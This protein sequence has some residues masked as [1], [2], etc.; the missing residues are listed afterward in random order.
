MTI[1][2]VLRDRLL[3]GSAAMLAL[4]V[5][6]LVAGSLNGTPAVGETAPTAL[7]KPPAD[8]VMGFVIERAVPPVL[9]GPDACPQGTVLRL[10]EE[11]LS[12][13]D[14][15]ERERLLKKENEPELDKRWRATAVGANDTNICSQPDMFER[16]QQRTVQ[17]KFAWGLDLDDGDAGDGCAHEEFASPDGRTGIDNQEYRAMG[18]TLEWRGKDGV[19]GDIASGLNQFHASGQWTQVLL[20]RGVDSLENDPDVEVIYANTSDRPT[21]GSNGKFLAHASF[22]VNDT[23]PRRRNML[24]GRI[25]NGVLVTEPEDIRLVQTWGQG[26]ARDIRGNRTQFDYR[27]A[28]LRLAFQ[29][30]GSLRG[31]M[32]GYRPVFDVI[33][34]PA[35]GGIGAAVAAG[36]DCAAVLSTL[37]RNA[38]GIRDPKTGKCTGVSSALDLAAVPAFVTDTPE[39]EA[40][41]RLPSGK[42]HS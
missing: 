11:Y 17:S 14:P 15:A 35:I 2:P 32:G 24:K 20:L 18:C 19:A 8:G 26:G 39:G 12:T 7:P 25:E 42:G 21:V 6:V 30:D 1:G 41:A 29:P 16:P 3:A 38:D 13:L 33:Q 5:V 23:P 37:N 9:Q 31:L 10:K 4:T 28:R 36:I 34:S 40:A 22:V 27:K